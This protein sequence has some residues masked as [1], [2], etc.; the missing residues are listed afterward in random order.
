M[1]DGYPRA[2]TLA[3]AVGAGLVAGVLFAFS[4][5]VM[6]ALR[7][8]PDSQGLTAMQAINKAAP[9]SLL[10]MTALLG[11][12]AV[13]VGLG[14]SALTRLDEPSA[15]YELVGCV[16]YLGCVAITAIYHVPRN[17]LLA[18][19][20]PAGTGAGDMWQHYLRG[21]TAWNHVR[22]LTAVASSV[23]LVLALRAT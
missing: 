22:T 14:I 2:L 12:G 16:L 10:F 20:D 18:L 23:V 19:V 15:A 5:F 11:T 17:D 21:W 4:T 1:I 8:L 6:P 13:C 9:S 7:R 3:V